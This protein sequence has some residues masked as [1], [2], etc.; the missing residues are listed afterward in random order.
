M[1]KQKYIDLG[2]LATAF[3][4]ALQSKSVR[5]KVGAILVQQTKTPI[6]VLNHIVAEGVNGT[7][8]GSNELP[9]DETGVTRSTVIHAEA[10]AI[11]KALALSLE[12]CGTTLYITHSPC[13]NCAG[14]IIKSKIKRVVYCSSYKV[15]NTNLLAKNGVEV[16]TV[17]HQEIA[18]YQMSSVNKTKTDYSGWLRQCGFTEEQINDKCR[19]K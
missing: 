6:G 14:L 10:N 3:S 4:M 15:D 16:I 19:G 7:W 17:P 5:K 12:T 1:D 11:Q 9:E 13:A 8:S 18:E 2:Y